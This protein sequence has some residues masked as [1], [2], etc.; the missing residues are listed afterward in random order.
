MKNIYYFLLLLAFV[1]CD[2]E[3]EIIDTTTDNVVVSAYIYAD[4][5]IDSVRVTKSIPYTSDGELEVI[6]DLE[7]IINDG[8]EDILLTSIG[9]GYY[10]NLDYIVKTETTYQLSFDYNGKTISSETYIQAPVE[11]SLSRDEVELEKIEFTVGI[12]G[13][14]RPGTQVQ[15]VVDITWNNQY[16]DYY[17]VVI[18]N[19]EED[20][21]YV[22]SFFQQSELDVDR[23]QR[24]FR[25]EPEI[26]D[27]YSINSFQELQ[28][29]GTYEIIV[30]RL[31]AEYAA[32]YETVGSSTL[33][34]QE[35]PSNIEN[36]LG[37]FTGITP[38]YLYLEVTE[39]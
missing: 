35:P 5:A 25:T 38:H 28:T 19:I 15:E 18:S 34:I 27:T 3:T 31:N 21:E 13:P 2:Q 23:P 39:L 11:V 22:N 17:F 1:S 20:P 6:D 32:L 10:S 37:I 8:T 9:D 16:Q 24:I 4:Q 29:F 30:Y 7:I 14:G 12:G 26:M 33:S 36:G